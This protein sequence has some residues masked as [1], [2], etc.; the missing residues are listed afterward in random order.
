MIVLGEFSQQCIIIHHFVIAKHVYKRK[1]VIAYCS[2]AF[3]PA[4]LL[5]GLDCRS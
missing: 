3:S 1:F 2:L 4:P 5:L